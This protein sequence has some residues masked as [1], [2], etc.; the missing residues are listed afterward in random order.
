MSSGSIAR[1]S[2]GTFGRVRC[3]DAVHARLFDDELVI[4][5][6]AKGEYFALD[7][8]GARLWAG[9]QA[10]RSVEEIAADVVA[11]Y[12]VASDRALADLVA[13]GEELVAQGLMV[14]DE[15]SDEAPGHGQADGG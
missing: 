15:T 11:E 2:A 6:L 13:L 14:R 10:G 12:D 9:L 3:A 5:N 8:L 4:L 7:A 1:A